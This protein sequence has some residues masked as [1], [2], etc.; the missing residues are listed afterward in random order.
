MKQTW[1]RITVLMMILCRNKKHHYRELSQE[2]KQLYGRM[3]MEFAD[4]WLSR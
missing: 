3:P 4:Y 2:A 1:P